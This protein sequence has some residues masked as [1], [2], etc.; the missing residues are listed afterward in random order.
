MVP[1]EGVAADLS[2]IRSSCSVKAYSLSSSARPVV[3]LPKECLS[4]CSLVLVVAGV[5]RKP[6]Q[7]KRDLVTINANI[8][9]MLV[10]ACAKHCPQAIVGLLVNPLNS[11]VP[12]MA[13][14]YEKKGLD[15]KKILGVTSLDVIRA[16]KFAHE[17]TGVP[18]EDLKVP[19]IGGN[20]GKSILPLFSQVKATA[21]L[22]IERRK[23]LDAQVRE[24]GSEIVKAKQGKGPATLSMG[25]AAYI[26]C[27]A[28]LKGL[29]GEKSVE[30]AFIKSSVT[31][32][33]FFSSQVTFGRNG[34]EKVHTVPKLDSYEQQ[35]LSEVSVVLKED[36]E[37][38][39][40]YAKKNELA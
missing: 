5:P 6:N 21:S 29:A 31:Q 36:I 33:P 20:A 22:P 24:A 30:C 38:G 18:L 4:G 9:K 23:A 16:S 37:L 28:V 10:E 27:S 26:F 13:G 12:A 15:P 39:L 25:Y 32:L 1:A 11:I 2:H 34:V 14:L 35:R 8:A 40:E 3:D 17:E 19:V 7:D